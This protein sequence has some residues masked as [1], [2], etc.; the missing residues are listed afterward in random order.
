MQTL[1]Y[2]DYQSIVTPFKYYIPKL[3]LTCKYYIYLTHLY[4]PFNVMVFT[5]VVSMHIAIALRN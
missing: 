2:W 1:K 3:M 5:I 4:I